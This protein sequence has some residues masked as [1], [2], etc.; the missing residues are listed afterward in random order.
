MVGHSDDDD[1]IAAKFP[2]TGAG[3][4]FV[5]VL[6]EDDI[7]FDVVAAEVVGKVCPIVLGVFKACVTR[8]LALWTDL[9]EPCITFKMNSNQMKPLAYDSKSG[10]MYVCMYIYVIDHS[11]LGL[12]RVNVEGGIGRQHIEGAPLAAAS[13][14][15]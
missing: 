6:S 2:R 10:H 7:A 3:E 4:E 15:I 8:N 11:S 12:F 9:L 1:G 13:V 14:H 5:S